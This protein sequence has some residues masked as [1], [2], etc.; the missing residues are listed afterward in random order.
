[1]PFAVAIARI[2]LD[3]DQVVA[4]ELRLETLEDRGA[5]A[6]DRE[7]RATRGLGER[8]QA[9][10]ADPAV[11][12]RRRRSPSAV[13]VEGGVV[14]VQDVKV[15]ARSRGQQAELFGEGLRIVDDEPLGD[16]EDSLWRV[17]RPEFREHVDQA[18]D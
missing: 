12:D 4:G 6:V 1:M 14:E 16:Q 15:G 2:R 8:F 17:N 10:D 18:V 13:R 3:A 9:H 5:G 11:L 7:Q